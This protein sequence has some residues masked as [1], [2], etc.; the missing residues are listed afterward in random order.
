MNYFILILVAALLILDVN[1]KK[2]GYPVEHSGCKYTC[3]KNEYC[4]KVCK[5]LKGEG[6]YCYINLTCWCTGLPDNVP[7]KTNQRCNGKRK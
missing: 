4:D 2:D 1:C 3:W 5:D 6:G 7:L